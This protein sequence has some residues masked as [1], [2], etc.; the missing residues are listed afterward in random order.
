[1]AGKGIGGLLVACALCGAGGFAALVAADATAPLP[2]NLADGAAWSA[3]WAG[4]DNKLFFV[5]G[6]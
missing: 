2:A 5:G 1:M 3:W 6:H 4:I